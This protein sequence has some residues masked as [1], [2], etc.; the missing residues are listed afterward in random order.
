MPREPR[1][2]FTV[3]NAQLTRYSNFSGR[4]T[5]FNA[6]GG[7]RTFSIILDDP[8]V[9][10]RMAEDG[11]N[12]KFPKPGEEDERDVT[13]DVKVKFDRMPPRIVVVT[14]TSRFDL[15]EDTVELLDSMDIASC[16]IICNASFYDVNGKTGIAAYLKK[17][18]VVIEEDELDKKW[19][20]NNNFGESE[21][22]RV[23]S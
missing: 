3:E 11:W 17:M 15:N 6:Q 2:T 5:K 8:K 23:D 16:D 7:D 21:I 1:Q 18:V 20:L 22:E 19:G 9:A 12:V 14:S 10:Q 4:P 13:I